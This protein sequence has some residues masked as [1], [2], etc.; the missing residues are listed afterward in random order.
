MFHE[1]ASDLRQSQ[2]AALVPVLALEPIAARAAGKKRAAARQCRL[3][4]TAGS[5]RCWR[6]ARVVIGDPLIRSRSLAEMAVSGSRTPVME[7][8]ICVSIIE[9]ARRPVDGEPVT[10]APPLS[11]AAHRSLWVGHPSS[12]RSSIE[13]R[14]RVAPAVAPQAKHSLVAAS[15]VGRCDPQFPAVLSTCSTGVVA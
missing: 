12:M 11:R 2:N 4:V 5:W 8:Q 14:A 1:E 13:Q 10:P 6:S 15:R 7:R 9:S 3:P